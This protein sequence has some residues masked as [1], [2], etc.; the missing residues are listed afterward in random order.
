[1]MVTEDDGLNGGNSHRFQRSKETFG[2]RDPGKSNDS[3]T[4]E[5]LAGN[6]SIL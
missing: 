2:F 1:M 4:L 3:Q 5:T 6:G